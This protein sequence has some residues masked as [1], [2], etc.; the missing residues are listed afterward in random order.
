MTCQV[1]LSARSR[2]I[3]LPQTDARICN[4]QP[5][6]MTLKLPLQTR[7]MRPESPKST[8]QRSVPMPCFAHSSQARRSGEPCR[9]ASSRR[10][11]PTSTA[12]IQDS[13]EKTPTAIAFAKWS[14]PAEQ[15]EDYTEPSWVWPEGTDTGELDAWTEATE[16]ASERI[17]GS[18]SCY[19]Q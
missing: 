9:A 12:D 19:C 2:L 4:L 15:G 14:L 6:A 17:I 3:D 1:L 18:D 5:Y 10:P 7:P 8:W 11:W 16:A 13:D